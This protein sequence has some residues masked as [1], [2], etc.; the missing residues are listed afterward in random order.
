MGLEAIIAANAGYTKPPGCT[1]NLLR[2]NEANGRPLR[3]RAQFATRFWNLS[4][5]K[6]KSRPRGRLLETIE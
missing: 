2:K 3:P 4:T 5:K 6:K 1:L